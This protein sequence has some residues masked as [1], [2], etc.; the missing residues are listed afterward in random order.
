MSFI[1]RDLFRKYFHS[2]LQL[3]RF[4]TNDFTL[5]T[6]NCGELRLT[7]EGIVYTIS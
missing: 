5:R 4:G 6:H 3:C 2:S 7:N 1:I